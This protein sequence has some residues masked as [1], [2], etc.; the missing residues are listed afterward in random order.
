MKPLSTSDV[1]VTGA[2][3]TL[4]YALHGWGKTTQ[5]A[6][7]K[8]AYGNGFIISGESGLRSLK[9]HDI[10]YFPFSSW[11]GP[12][13]PAN[14]VFSFR[15]ICRW[16]TTPEFKAD[17]YRWVMID[18]LTELSDQLHAYLKANPDL[19]ETKGGKPNPLALWGTYGELMIGALKWVRDLP[20]HVLVTA[21]A[22]EGEDDNGAADYWP[23]IKGQTAQKQIPG[24]FD[25][26]F[27]GVRVTSGDRTAPQ[28]ERYIVTD[29]VRGWHGKVRD[30]SK[31]LQ[32]VEKCSD[33][34][35]LFERM[36][37]PQSNYELWLA[38]QTA[39]AQQPAT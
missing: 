26:V 13:D 25:N 6:Y 35:K 21:L 23:A 9:E 7:Y 16:M 19:W 11:D 14:G 36:E 17:G 5:A 24:I 10:P 22:K 3:K 33:I 32:P 28:V 31:R 1:S 20:M 27:G 34:T 39:A 8:K 4:L 29:E 15:G 2:S 38:G 37:M 12:H 30:P 18:S